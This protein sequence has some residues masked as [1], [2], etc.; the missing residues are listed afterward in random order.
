MLVKVYPLST[1]L[2]ENGKSGENRR[3]K[4]MGLTRQAC[5]ATCMP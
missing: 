3:R 4:T 5:T 1:T 2:I